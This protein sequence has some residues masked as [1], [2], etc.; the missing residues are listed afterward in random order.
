[1]N[2]FCSPS[3]NKKCKLLRAQL[4]TDSVCKFSH[5][6]AVWGDL[7]R[8]CFTC[9]LIFV[10]CTSPCSST[11]LSWIY[12]FWIT[13]NLLFYTAKNSLQF[14][15]MTKDLYFKWLNVTYQ[16]RNS[17]LFW[18]HA[19]GKLGW[20]VSLRS[21]RKR[22]WYYGMK[23]CGWT[24]YCLWTGGMWDV[25]L[26]SSRL[27]WWLVCRRWSYWKKHMLRDHLLHPPFVTNL[28]HPSYR[29]GCLNS[30]PFITFRTLL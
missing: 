11:I 4:K 5:R 30:H 28:L 9:L 3:W 1:M 29:T 2:L 8:F 7:R 17:P 27:L 25:L 14:C 18:G 26:S 24:A 6:G 19:K 16:Q 10:C 12:F 23:T 21:A 13:H 15:Q 22:G 20:P